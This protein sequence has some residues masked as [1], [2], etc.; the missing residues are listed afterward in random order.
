MN[1]KSGKGLGTTGSVLAFGG[2]LLLGIGAGIVINRYR[3]KIKCTKIGG[4]WDE[5]T[6]TC[7]LPLKI[8]NVDTRVLKDAYDNLTFETGKAIITKNSYPFLD[9]I[10]SV[11]AN[12]TA[13]DWRLEIKG[14]TDNVGGAEYNQKLSEDRA[15]SVKK[16]LIS[17]GIEQNRITAKGYGYS[18]PIESNNTTEGRRR[19]RRVEFSILK[20]SGEILTGQPSTTLKTATN[21]SETVVITKDKKVN[22][23][24]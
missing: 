2:A 19:N 14:H 1:K 5:K 8:E 20:P 22:L 7:A 12:P 24:S 10:A 3:S 9:E 17:K 18:K 23:S 13:K 16:Y 6:Q 21:I 4:V 11:F 15:Q